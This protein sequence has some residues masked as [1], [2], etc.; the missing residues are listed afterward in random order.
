MFESI[1]TG[2]DIH[3]EMFKDT[4]ASNGDPSVEESLSQ[5]TIT[6]GDKTGVL[7]HISVRKEID[8]HWQLAGHLTGRFEDPPAGSFRFENVDYCIST[9]NPLKGYNNGKQQWTIRAVGKTIRKRPGKQL[10]LPPFSGRLPLAP[11]R[12]ST[13]FSLTAATARHSKVGEDL[14][15]EDLRKRLKE[16]NERIQ[17]LKAQMKS[18][19][20]SPAT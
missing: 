12:I 14:F 4:S 13:A 7:R 18:W 11:S 3:S 16:S 20:N 10:G 9:A 5:A 1:D 6:L 2:N 8:G 17:Q 15:G 19:S